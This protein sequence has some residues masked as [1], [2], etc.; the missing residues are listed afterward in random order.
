MHGGVIIICAALFM[1]AVPDNKAEQSKQLAR[2]QQ[3]ILAFA[4]VQK[5]Y[6]VHKLADL[7]FVQGFKTARL[8][9]KHFGKPAFCLKLQK[10]RFK[11]QQTVP[12]I[13]GLCDYYTVGSNFYFLAVKVCCFSVL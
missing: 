2:K 8:S 6:F 1:L 4:F 3:N 5:Y 9:V 11:R 7:L 13:T 12:F 10:C